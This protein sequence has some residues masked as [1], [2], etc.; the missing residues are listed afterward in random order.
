[1]PTNFNLIK[2]RTRIRT[3]SVAKIVIEQEGNR[4]ALK[5]ATEKQNF[6]EK[7]REIMTELNLTWEQGKSELKKRRVLESMSRE[8][9]ELNLI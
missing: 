7:V 1:V 6:G 2:M 9:Q 4:L 5:E 8:M 3:S